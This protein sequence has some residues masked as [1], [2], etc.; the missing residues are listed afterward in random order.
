MS[1]CSTIKRVADIIGANGARRYIVVSAP[2]VGNGYRY[3]VTDM[4][5]RCFNAI[6]SERVELFNTVVDRFYHIANE[7]IPYDDIT[8][9][10]DKYRAEL[11][12][13]ER[14]DDI[15]AM[16]EHL[17]AYI[18]AK[19]ISFDFV[20]SREL[21]CF[22]ELGKLDI[23][24]SI[25]S[26]CKNLKKHTNAVISGFYGRDIKGRTTLLTRG[27]SDV[28][29]A[30]VSR[31]VQ[32]DIYE[33]WS[34]VS[35]YYMV[36]PTIINEPIKIESLSYDELRRLS[37]WSSS[38]IHRDT[39]LPLIGSK[40]IIN[41]RNSF[42]PDD[43]GTEI[44]PSIEKKGEVIGIGGK[45][46]LRYLSIEKICVAN[47]ISAL[48]EFINKI[49]YCSC[50]SDR[51]DLI[52][53][54]ITEQK[55]CFDSDSISCGDISVISIIIGK[56]GN[57]NK[58]SIKALTLLLDNQIEVKMIHIGVNCNDILI[59]VDDKDYIDAVKMLYQGLIDDIRKYRRN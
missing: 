34:D 32:A 44:Y 18:L 46:H 43:K 1:G 27:G 49:E 50:L 7:L 40:T 15:V 11:D 36:D 35:G 5:Y 8:F 10:I 54:D 31:A 37:V 16:G 6:G 24:H 17:S 22:D 41:V 4:L 19:Y 42:S 59:A 13:S 51:I 20:D 39:I 25:E 9:I 48:G 30:L 14:V 52:G 3:K 53:I 26:T 38:V 57:I 2:G 12:R 28:T 21:V 56:N 47:E 45:R 29:G 33:N 55:Y 58:L 23:E